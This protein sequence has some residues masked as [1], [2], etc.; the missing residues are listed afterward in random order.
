MKH[1]LSS[2][3]CCCICNFSAGIGRTGTFIERD[4]LYKEGKRTGKINV[5]KYVNTMR[6]CRM[7][8]VQTC[9]S[10]NL[11]IDQR[12][13]TFKKQNAKLIGHIKTILFF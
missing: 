3:F 10:V 13:L 8:M 11:Y 9:V 5:M 6:S 7:N 1:M 12:N 2:M 4:A